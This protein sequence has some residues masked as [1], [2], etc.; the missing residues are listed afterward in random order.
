MNNGTNR[1]NQSNK[2]NDMEH[3]L[4]IQYDCNLQEAK[5]KDYGNAYVNDLEKYGLIAAN[6]MI[7]HKLSRLTRLLS[8]TQKVTEESP[9]ETWIDLVNY[10]VMTINYIKTER[11]ELSVGDANFRSMLVALQ[12][13]RGHKAPV[14]HCQVLADK[15]LMCHKHVLFIELYVRQCQDI[16]N[17]F[18]AIAEVALAECLTFDESVLHSQY[19][20]NG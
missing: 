8:N 19:L 16:I 13:E 4:F 1:T 17:Y 18:I 5:N 3:N 2:I 15:L 6:I 11:P 12:P 20:P 14:Q 9:F 7:D 10:C